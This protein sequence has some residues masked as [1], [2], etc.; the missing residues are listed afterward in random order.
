[1][2]TFILNLML[3]TYFVVMIHAFNSVLYANNFT[4]LYYTFVII[5]PSY[6]YSLRRVGN[7]RFRTTKFTVNKS[8][9]Q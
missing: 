7:S 4:K 5:S 3:P 8:Y 6:F 9:L 2:Y 1:M